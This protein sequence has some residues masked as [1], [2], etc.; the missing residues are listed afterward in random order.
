MQWNNI[1]R[2]N[3]YNII[4]HFLYRWMFENGKWITVGKWCI[5]EQQ[6]VFSLCF[7]WHPTVLFLAR[8]TIYE[9][10][11][12]PLVHLCNKI[13]TSNIITCPSCGSS[14]NTYSKKYPIFTTYLFSRS[15]CPRD[16][17]THTLSHLECPCGGL[18]LTEWHQDRHVSINTSVFLSQ[19]HCTTTSYLYYIYLL[20]TLYNHNN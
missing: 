18:W 5:W 8:N 11:S 6:T 15:E 9:L 4:L 12:E 13:P 14:L 20:Q 2:K 19:Y 10:I 16:M 7:K 3:A 17:A 1:S